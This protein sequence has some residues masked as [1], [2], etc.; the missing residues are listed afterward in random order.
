MEPVEH[1]LH[2]LNQLI[3]QGDEICAALAAAPGDGATEA[4]ARVW[5]R[6]C[7]ALINELSGGSKAHWLSRAFSEAFLIRAATN[8][9]ATEVDP[10]EIVRRIVDVLG[11]GASSLTSVAQ[12]GTAGQAAAPAPRPHRFDFVHKTG[13]RPILEGALTDSQQALERG[14]FLQALLLSCSILDAILT[15]ALEGKGHDQSGEWTFE[16]RIAA[17]EQAGLIRNSC[18]RLPPVARQYRDLTDEAGEA[19]SDAQIS[20]RDPR[21]AAQVLKIVMND[22]DPGR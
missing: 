2:H 21:V 6:D 16:L 5:Q 19:R 7:A 17:A 1:A 12:Q 20:A 10:V 13:L 8:A 14:D 3:R 11:R 4:A 9:P 15:D 18:A 22:L